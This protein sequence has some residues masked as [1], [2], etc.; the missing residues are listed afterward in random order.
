[1]EDARLK[2]ETAACMAF[3]HEDVRVNDCDLG[4]DAGEE[5]WHRMQV[6]LTKVRVLDADR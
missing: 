1:M 2:A 5:G 6:G 3:C 4:G